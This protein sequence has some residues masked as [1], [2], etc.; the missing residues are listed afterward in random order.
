LSGRL[1]FRAALAV[2]LLCAQAGGL[3]HSLSHLAEARLQLG[4]SGRQAAASRDNDQSA[5]DEHCKLCDAYAQI[6]NAVGCDI[7]VFTPV[8]LPNAVESDCFY[9][10]LSAAPVPFSARAPPLSA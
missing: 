7:I 1:I 5:P 9:S 8:S 10:H 3:M 4:D 6:A 2:A